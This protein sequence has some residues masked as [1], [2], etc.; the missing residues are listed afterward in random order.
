MGRGITMPT[1]RACCGRWC[2]AVD[3][4]LAGLSAPGRGRIAGLAAEA[5]AWIAK[6]RV[7]A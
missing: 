5:T 3:P 2:A 6:E 4:V 1:S 7:S